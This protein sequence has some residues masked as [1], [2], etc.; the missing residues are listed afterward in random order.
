ML[1]RYQDPT[2]QAFIGRLQALEHL[3]SGDAHEDLRKLMDEILASQVLPDAN[4]AQPAGKPAGKPK[5][6]AAALEIAESRGSY[7]KARVAEHS[8]LQNR[9]EPGGFGLWTSDVF[10]GGGFWT[11][12]LSRRSS[13]LL[14]FLFLGTQ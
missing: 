12:G 1:Q 8:S 7:A 13:F 9:R 2:M 3:Y 10:L 14:S 5:P 6:K 4:A 11:F